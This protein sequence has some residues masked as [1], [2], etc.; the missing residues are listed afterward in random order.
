MARSRGSDD[1]LLPLPTTLRDETGRASVKQAFVQF[2]PRAILVAVL[3]LAV[4]VLAVKAVGVARYD[5]AILGYS[6]QVDDAEGVV[7]AEASLIARGVN[8]YAH[9]PSP[10]SY[11]YAGPYTPLY[12]LIN[13]LGIAALGPTFKVGRVVQLLATLGVGAWLVW[14]VGGRAGRRA[15]WL[16]GVWTAL[17]FLTAHLVALWGALVRPDMTAL[18]WN[19]LGVAVLRRWWDTNERAGWRADTWP[20]GR[21]LGVVALG[22]ACFALG[23][24]TKQTALAVP[25]AFAL[26]LLLRRPKVAVA[27]VAVYMACIVIPFAVLTA[28]TGGGFAQKVIGYQGSWQWAAYRR[29]AQPF[30]ARYSVLLVLAALVALVS[31]ARQRRLTFAAAWFVF[32][33][34]A[35]FGAGTSGGN[36]NHFVELLAAA[37]LLVGQGVAGGVADTDAPG[38]AGWLVAV[39]VAAIV[40]LLT[41]ITAT[42]QEGRHGWLAR[43]YRAPTASERAGWTQVASY[44]ANSPAPVYSDNVGILV[45]AGQPVRVTDPFTMAAEV[46]LGRWD[47]AALVD[48]ILAGRYAVI[49]LRDDVATLDPDHPPTDATPALI[50]AVRARYRLAEKNVRMLYV[51]K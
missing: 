39:R 1:I 42:E 48:D 43:E 15:G 8:P 40:L 29:L 14:A 24:W 36:H 38:R 3:L 45:V 32:A 4:V 18:V 12:T 5:A 20:R 46:R 44:L 30:A 17:V 9:Q 34:L 37:C 6:F 27:T 35:A 10:S 41:G 23:W 16:V 2:G 51:P 50:R 49:A 19:L 7:L 47:D 22:A 11:F 31:C 33:A 28:L 21:S 26:T 25:A 13:T